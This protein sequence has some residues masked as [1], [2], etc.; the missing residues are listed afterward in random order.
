M[1][2]FSGL[3]LALGL[4]FVGCKDDKKID[5]NAFSSGKEM[6]QDA[7]DAA[8]NIDKKSY[9]GLEGV[10]QDT[11]D[12]TANGKYLLLVFGKNNCSYCE[13]LK[14]DLKKHKDLQEELKKDFSPYY[15]NIS[16]EKTHNFSFSDHQS[17]KVMTSQ[18]ANNIYSIRVTPTLIFGE[19]DGKTILEI[20]GYVRPEEFQKILAFITEG[21]WKKAK[22]AK[23]RMG[24][25]RK[26]LN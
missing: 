5:S 21:S 19:K 7:K 16:Y 13:K 6:Q 3:F 22:D 23:E 25:L 17:A 9:A 12:I 8:Q 14:N 15:I 26:Y 11:G 18:L 20:P 1:R 2:F 24:L 4:F 10:F